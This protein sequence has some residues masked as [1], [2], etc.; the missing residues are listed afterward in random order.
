MPHEADFTSHQLPAWNEQYSQS[1][2]QTSKQEYSIAYHYFIDVMLHLHNYKLQWVVFP[3]QML[4]ITEW[5]DL[6][7]A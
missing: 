7:V 6:N 1:S 5:Y 4:V 3:T 2:S